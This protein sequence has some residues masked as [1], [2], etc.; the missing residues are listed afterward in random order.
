VTVGSSKIIG[1]PTCDT[2]LPRGRDRRDMVWFVPRTPNPDSAGPLLVRV[3]CYAGRKADERPVRF[4][5][6][7]REYLVEEV[8][9]VV[10][11]GR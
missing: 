9:S 10:R 3:Q 7:D 1:A 4:Q 11:A 5:V 6:G 8:L 2:R